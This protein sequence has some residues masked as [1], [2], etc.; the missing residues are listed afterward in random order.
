MT[1]KINEFV[2]SGPYFKCATC[3]NNI[4]EFRAMKFPMC[5]ECMKDLR[6][7]IYERRKP[8]VVEGEQ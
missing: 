2:S 7:I 4:T 5:D 3:D 1:I 8:K 6:G